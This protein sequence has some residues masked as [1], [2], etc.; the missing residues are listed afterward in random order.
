VYEP[1][2]EVVVPC[3]LK[4]KNTKDEIQF[5]NQKGMLKGLSALVQLVELKA[6]Q[7]T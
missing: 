5:H 4:N 3:E 1:L 2:H 7:I 6:C